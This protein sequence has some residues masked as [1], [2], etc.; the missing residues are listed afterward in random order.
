MH[1]WSNKCR[2]GVKY[3]IPTPT[4]EL[5]CVVMYLIFTKWSRYEHIK[6]FFFSRL[7]HALYADVWTCHCRISSV[8]TS[9][10]VS[11]PLQNLLNRVVNNYCV[12]YNSADWSCIAYN[13]LVYI[14][15]NSQ[16]MCCMNIF[17]RTE[18]STCSKNRLHCRSLPA[19]LLLLRCAA[20]L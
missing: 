7:W 5:N 20:L 8:L 16:K 4:F 19:V 13:S 18:H 2:L 9:H 11:K 10:T 14:A 1:F 12:A 15:Y 6:Q 17:C 3:Y